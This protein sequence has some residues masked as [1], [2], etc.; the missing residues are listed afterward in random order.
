MWAERCAKFHMSRIEQKSGQIPQLGLWIA[1]YNYVGNFF[2]AIP[3][4]CGANQMLSRVMCCMTHV[5]HVAQFSHK[6]EFACLTRCICTHAS[7]CLLHRATFPFSLPIPCVYYITL[8]DHY[9]F[10]D[11]V[12]SEFAVTIV[13]AW[14]TAGSWRTLRMVPPPSG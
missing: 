4:Q 2:L 1:V 8:I 14:V 13:A 7:I 11:R 6:R 10:I 3:F 9:S 12:G 5:P